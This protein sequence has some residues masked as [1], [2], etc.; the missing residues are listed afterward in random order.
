MCEI[1]G[2]PDELEYQIW[3]NDKSLELDH[4]GTG[5]FRLGR[6]GKLPSG[7]KSV[8]FADMGEFVDVNFFTSSLR[9]I[10]GRSLTFFHF[11]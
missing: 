11:R 6:T 2:K 4:G 1:P 8:G 7:T 3:I 10:F 5:G 9:L